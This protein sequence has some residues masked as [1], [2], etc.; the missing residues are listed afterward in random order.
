L[1]GTDVQVADC[2]IL[3]VTDGLTDI[4]HSYVIKE[5]FVL[6]FDLGAMIV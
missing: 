3:S 5:E 2:Y 4:T 6:E 1:I